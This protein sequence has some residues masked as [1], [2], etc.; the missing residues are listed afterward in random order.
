GVVALPSPHSLIPIT[1]HFLFASSIFSLNDSTKSSRGSKPACRKE[2]CP[3]RSKMIVVGIELIKKWASKY[4][5]YATGRLNLCC[6]KNGSTTS[7]SSSVVTAR[8]TTSLSSLYFATVFSNC[9]I[10]VKQGPHQVAQKL[11][12]I[13]LP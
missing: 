3:W 6:F 4:S 8:K 2:T 12:T 13:T 9:G 11:N 1:H 10:S 5:A 7:R